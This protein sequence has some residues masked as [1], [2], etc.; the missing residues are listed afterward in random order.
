MRIE[1]EHSQPL[2]TTPK[3]SSGQDLMSNRFFNAKYWELSAKSSLCIQTI[4]TMSACLQIEGFAL[5]D[6]YLP[7][8]SSTCRVDTVRMRVETSSR[9][10]F[11]AF[12]QTDFFSTF[13]KNIFSVDQK[14]CF[15]DFLKK[16]WKFSDFWGIFLDFQHLKIFQIFE[17]FFV[18]SFFF[19]FYRSIFF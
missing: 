15:W 7:V 1:W 17:I 6:G 3:H 9:M 5:S 18:D 4:T 8:S 13:L 11:A 2:K 12:L 16:S 14:N 10:L 19:F